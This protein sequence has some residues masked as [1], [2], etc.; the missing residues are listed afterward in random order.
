MAAHASSSSHKKESPF[1][2]PIYNETATFRQEHESVVR[3][4][5]HGHR[6]GTAYTAIREF[7]ASHR[8]HSIPEFSERLLQ[9]AE[10]LLVEMVDTHTYLP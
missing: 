1:F 10:L 8:R 6:V 4:Q 9:Y 3:S 7:V 2:Q 5:F